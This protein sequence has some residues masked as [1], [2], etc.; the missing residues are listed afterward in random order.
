LYLF[1]IGAIK[2]SICLP[3][4]SKESLKMNLINKLK[5]ISENVFGKDLQ[6]SFFVSEME[7]TVYFL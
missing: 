4:D 7:Q 5:K 6:I 2:K 1:Y 3:R